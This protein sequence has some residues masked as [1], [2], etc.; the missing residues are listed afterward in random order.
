MGW[1]LH[2]ITIN[3]WELHMQDLDVC[4]NIIYPWAVYCEGPPSFIWRKGRG[5]QNWGTLSRGFGLRSFRPEI[6]AWGVYVGRRFRPE[7]FLSAAGAISTW[8]E[9]SDI[10]GRKLR[11]FERGGEGVGRG[12]GGGNGFKYFLVKVKWRSSRGTCAVCHP[13]IL[14][15]NKRA[16]HIDFR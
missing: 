7:E 16:E 8:A 1:C 12:G 4:P 9:I 11:I 5:K 14:F 3:Y 13:E 6:S 10:S 2:T 15:L